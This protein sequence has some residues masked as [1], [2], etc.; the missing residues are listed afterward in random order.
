MVFNFYKLKLV[1]QLFLRNGNAFSKNI[2]NRL[3]EYTFYLSQSLQLHFMFGVLR[4]G[5]FLVLLNQYF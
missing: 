2:D 1:K 5:I 4:T 3:R